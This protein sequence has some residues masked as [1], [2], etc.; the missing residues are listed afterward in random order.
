MNP[1][2]NTYQ[3]GTIGS[4]D[5]K[6]LVKS[7]Q[8]VDK[9]L[10][11]KDVINDELQVP[12][13]TRPRRWGKSSN[14][15]MLKTFLEIEID[16]HGNELPEAQKVNPTYFKGGEICVGNKKTLYK[17]LRVVKC[18]DLLKE[19]ENDPMEY[20]GKHPVILMSF[21]DLGGDSYEALVEDLKIKF[22]E[23]F[24]T[25]Q[26]LSRSDKLTDSEKARINKHLVGE[27]SV[28]FI[29]NAIKF[30]TT[31][32]YKHFG[33]KVWVLIDEYDNAIHRAY[34]EF[35]QDAKNPRQFSKEFKGVL[36]L[37]RDLMSAAFKDNDYLERGVITGIL[38]IAQ[39]NLFS[40]LSNVKEYGVLNKRFARYYGFEQHEVDI[41]CK[42]YQIPA[43]KQ[44]QLAEWY[45]GYSY[46][47]LKLY[48]PWSIMN[49]MT[50]EDG[51]LKN[52]W[53]STSYGALQNLTIT[54][55]LQ[56][57]LQ[58]LL[59]KKINS[60]QLY[61]GSGFNL[62]VLS[63]GDTNGMKVLLLLAGYLNPLQI[64]DCNY[65]TLYEVNIPNQEV[66]IALADLIQTWI[67]N[68][69]GI[70]IDKLK[71][72]AAH[73]MQGNVD[74]LQLALYKF[75]QSTLSFRIMH[76]AEEAIDLKES[77]YHFLMIG[78]LNGIM[79]GYDV[80]HEIESGRGYVDTM[81]IP[82]ALFCKS[83]QAIV[84]EYKYAKE[85]KNLQQEAQDGLEQIK[86][87]N[88][89][90]IIEKEQHVK[91]VLQIGMAFHQKEI[92]MVHE[93]KPINTLS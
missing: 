36:A 14:I 48:N 88:Y 19:R 60:T 29:K 15:S 1:E 25:H 43:H 91:S 62:N 28:G 41:L 13:I 31:C 71:S 51:Y 73:L 33:K 16:E 59:S 40:G 64:E 10:F 49:C 58:D 52:Y 76:E 78:L 90:A 66:R 50:D 27:V 42:Q 67:A 12:L 5:F 74:Q 86:Q 53:E 68:K 89:V 61:L 57:E 34:T 75:L 38:R 2:N 37:F 9:S 7:G 84:L 69:L 6:N 92:A 93:I 30:L 44:K 80:T 55:D 45:N 22:I 8:Y 85:F 39:A 77:H 21:K 81:I 83:T 87:K 24:E 11:I 65:P 54:E 18:K 35:G 20:L 23:V 72:I 70:G 4:N 3:K 17:E 79:S 56:Q 63:D 32:I 26:Y 82:K 47:G 46:G